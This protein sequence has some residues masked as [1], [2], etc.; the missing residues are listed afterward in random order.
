MTGT[1][2]RMQ[3]DR[4]SAVGDE[5]LIKQCLKGDQQAWAALIEKYKNLI[6]SIPIKMGMY[7]DAGDIFQA[8]CV[9]LL[10]ELP[11][12]REYKALPKW[13]MQTCYHKCLHY[14]KLA[15]RQVELPPTSAEGQESPEILPEHML[16]ALEKE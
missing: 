3:R 4:A 9:D 6:Y 11:R 14:Q 5:R 12:L 2:A 15:S 13:L 16:I 10:T 1:A 7:Q 8:V